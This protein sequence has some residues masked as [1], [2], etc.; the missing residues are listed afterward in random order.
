M[1]DGFHARVLW[2]TTAREM[3][4][5]EHSVDR[6]TMYAVREAGRRVKQEAK[7]NAP[8]LGDSR[9]ISRKA[10]RTGWDAGQFSAGGKTPPVKGLL[11]MSIH[12]SKRLHQDGRGGYAV[13]VAPRGE[14]VHFYSG[15]VEAIYGYMR[16][17]YDAVAPELTHIAADTWRKA[18]RGRR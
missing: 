7:R 18:T 16:K 4:R 15:Q 2:R 9:G 5:I 17:A 14:R 8:V 12:S 6:A 11:R 10:F 1:A 13:R 3:Q